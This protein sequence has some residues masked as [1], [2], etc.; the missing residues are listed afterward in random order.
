MAKDFTVIGR[1]LATPARSDMI[2]ALMDGSA[3]PASELASAAG[4]SPA[5]A[6]EHLAVLADAGLVTC[7]PQGRRRYYRLADGA[8]ASGLEHLGN[9]C[10]DAPAVTYRQSRDA[11]ALA[12]ARFCYDHLA[13][14]LGVALTDAMIAAGWLDE[15]DLAPTPAAPAAFSER[16]ID[17]D[18]LPS[19]RRIAR[20]CAD[21]TERR[22]HLAGALGAAVAA[23]FLD[24]GWVARIPEGRGLRITREGWT[25]LESR[26][27]VR[28][29]QLAADV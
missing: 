13:G 1:A 3:R 10:P 27:G 5:T 4:V 22:A 21:W 20:R 29:E 19:R 17:L 26:W 23:R 6:S 9:L 14:R 8:V 11:R 16:G 2:N 12:Q 25:A 18:A 15:T 7:T 24:A 28:R